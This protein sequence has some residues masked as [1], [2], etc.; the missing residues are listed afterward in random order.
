MNKCTLRSKGLVSIDMLILSLAGIHSIRQE[1]SIARYFWS[2]LLFILQFAF[3]K[4]VLSLV[5]T[6]NIRVR[7]KTN[8]RNVLRIEFPVMINFS[9]GKTLKAFDFSTPIYLGRV[10]SLLLRLLSLNFLLDV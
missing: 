1:T 2:L 4:V 10:T 6:T 5:C 9:V 3:G 8:Q 7:V